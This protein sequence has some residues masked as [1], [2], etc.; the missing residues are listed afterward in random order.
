[1]LY[2]VATPIGNL[3]DFTFRAVEVLNSVDYILSEDTRHSQILLGHY[4]IKTALYSFHRFNEAKKEERVLADLLEGKNIALI[5]DA[6]TPGIADPGNELVKR[7]LKEQ[8]KVVAIPGACAA[9]SALVSSGL[10]TSL[11][12]FCGFPP[13]QQMALRSF[14]SELLSYKG[15]SICYESPNR[16]TAT[17]QLL[18]ELAPERLVIVMREITKKFEQRYSGKAEEVIEQLSKQPVKGEIVLLIAGETGQNKEEWENITPFEQ[19]KELEERYKIKKKEAIKLAAN[20]RGI[21]P[22]VL[23]K[24]LLEEDKNS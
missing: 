18:S 21:S 9:V 14:L 16:I 5:S 10:D 7:C 23:Y 19:V 15:S 11:F 24:Q 6:G 4:Q 3:G 22:R 1:M 17:L 8:V 12:Q 13:R 2:L 20:L